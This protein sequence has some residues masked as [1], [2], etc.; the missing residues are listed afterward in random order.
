VGE[1][2]QVGAELRL[3]RLIRGYRAQLQE[4]LAQ[5]PPP[6]AEIFPNMR[7][8]S[9]L[10][11]MVEGVQAYVGNVDDVDARRVGLRVV[12]H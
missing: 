12:R 8:G 5:V 11:S 1:S 2:F 9:L 7:C 6:T 10:E 3:A 4:K